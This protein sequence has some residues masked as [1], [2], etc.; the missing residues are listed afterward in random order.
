MTTR[1]T[2]AHLTTSLGYLGVWDSAP[3]RRCGA[4][5]IRL[6][7]HN[8]S[9]LPR[10]GAPGDLSLS[11]SRSTCISHIF[12]AAVGYLGVVPPLGVEAPDLG[13]DQ[14]IIFDI[15]GNDVLV[16]PR[17]VVCPDPPP[18]DPAPAPA[19]PA[20]G[21]DAL[22]KSAGSRG[23]DGGG[24]PAPA[25]SR[26]VFCP[27]RSPAAGGRGGTPSRGVFCPLRSATTSLRASASRASAAATNAAV[28]VATLAAASRAARA[29]ACH[30]RVNT[31]RDTS[32]T[33]S[34]LALN[35]RHGGVERGG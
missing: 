35:S 8:L 15:I 20:P 3:T 30:G 2:Y 25:P 22:A 11:T 5:L 10:N 17:G 1:P 32:S 6:T 18:A 29:A 4:R 23:G 16:P 13:L 33:T 28:S 12:T 21:S 19:P 31:A 7:S 27:L 24:R 9:R 26:G 34:Q 14:P